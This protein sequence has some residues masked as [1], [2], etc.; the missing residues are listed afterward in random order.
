MLRTKVGNFS[1]VRIMEQAGIDSS[2]VLVRTVTRLL[3]EKGYYY[4]Q[5]QKNGLLKRDDLKTRLSF[6]K[7]CKKDF[8]ENFWTEHLSF[9]LDGT[10]FAPK[11]NPCDKG[12]KGKDMEKDIRG[13]YLAHQGEEK[14]ELAA[15]C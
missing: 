10:G 6:A 8:P 4:F 15:K 1:A 13:T 11:S 14:R 7:W 12:N 3:N 9:F 2:E 5:A